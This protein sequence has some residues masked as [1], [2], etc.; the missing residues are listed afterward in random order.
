MKLRLPNNRDLAYVALLAAVGLLAAFAPLPNPL[1]A[2][3]AAPL[4]LAL[5]GYAIASG[6]FPNRS[7]PL[8]ERALLTFVLSIAACVLPGLAVQIFFDFT[9]HSWGITLAIV[10]WVAAVWAAGRR[11]EAEP[12]D[13]AEP[14][15]TPERAAGDGVRT[16]LAG[17]LFVLSLVIAGVAVAISVDSVRDEER[18]NE[19][20]SLWAVP[21]GDGPDDGVTIGVWNH[22][23]PDGDYRLTV[24][25]DGRRL[26]EFDLTLDATGRWLWTIPGAV[27]EGDG[28]L[29]ITLTG[30]GTPERRVAL[31]DPLQ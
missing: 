6:L 7:F 28:R 5:P 11:W 30:Q 16:A 2:I 13:W 20:A 24:E 21:N 12:A 22:G 17:S 19:F 4:V 15:A 23:E 25:R 18:R 31:R 26:R 1:R 3:L 14:K 8:A 10:T 9:V 29:V 27:T